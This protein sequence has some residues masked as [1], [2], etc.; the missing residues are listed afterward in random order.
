MLEQQWRNTEV[1]FK[2]VFFKDALIQMKY[3][4]MKAVSAQTFS[5]TFTYSILKHYQA[6][7]CQSPLCG[8]YYASK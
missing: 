5:S 4:L 6:W 7:F 1:L 8:Q 3:T 2:D